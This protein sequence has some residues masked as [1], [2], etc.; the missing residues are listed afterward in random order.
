MMRHSPAHVEQ[1]LHRVYRDAPG[2]LSVVYLDATGKKF[3]G[4][5]GTVPDIASALERVARLDAAGA[6]GI[7]LRTTTL[8]RPLEA[9]ERGGA[10][11]SLTL[12]GLWADVDY[13]TVGHKPGRGPL[14]L[15]PD[16]HEARRIVTE[17]GLPAP[18][19]WVHSGGGWYPWWLLNEPL[20]LTDELRPM[21]ADISARW[22]KALG[23]SAERLGY[24]YGTGVGDLA[25][26]LR[27]PGTVNRKAGQERKCRVV[28]DHGTV[29]TLRELMVALDA[30]A[31]PPKTP[32]PAPAAARPYT[33]DPLGLRS[34]ISA[35]DALDEHVTF[36]DILAGAGFRLHAGSHSPDI[37]QCWTR[38]GDPDSP[39]NAHTLKANPHVLVVHSELAGLP[40]G[41]G[42]KLTRGRVF[43]QL[44]HGG[45][46]RAASLDLFAAMGNRSSTAAA[47]ALPLPRQATVTPIGT[48]VVQDIVALEEKAA[49]LS[50]QVPNHVAPGVDPE[51]GEVGPDYPEPPS[52]ADDTEHDEFWTSRPELAHLRDFARA[53]RAAPWAV[54]GCALTR[55]V[56][57][58]EPFVTLPPIIG[59]DASLNLFLGLVGPS[60]GG[61]GAAEAAAKDAVRF[62]RLLET[63]PVEAGVGSGEG[64]AHTY[65]RYV[66]GKKGEPGT[67]EQHNTR[68]IFR[69]PEVDTLAAL[70]GRQGSTLLPK[71]R[72]AW[73]GDALGFAYADVTRR[74]DLRAHQYRLCLIVGIQ[75][76]RAAVLLDD[77]DG[78]TPQRFLW[79]PT[80]DP[81][82]PAQAQIGRAHV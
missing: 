2:L 49:R 64:I 20:Q 36:D 38:P 76:N 50:A 7:Y 68:A 14:P 61:K 46:E 78:G 29:F 4:G 63:P 62:T 39:C 17:S 51:T 9:H 21:A 23:R 66:P 55:V 41:G 28:E 71:L 30:V 44:H 54:L 75:P 56:A 15:P 72:D 52:P 35:F 67:V 24:D 34:G 3:H 37:D 60:G 11:D 69:A 74:L 73:I 79:L 31:P 59:G 16:E 81:H 42:Q 58:V 6:Q 82:V 25:R 26:V 77:A 27:I 5:G 8:N 19:L 22:Q 12:P 18:S 53:R 47:S 33:G 65:L 70:K 45:D 1:W 48:S 10:A 43:A 32:S 40:T 13:G 57:H 80:M